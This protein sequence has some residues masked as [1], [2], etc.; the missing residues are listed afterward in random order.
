MNGISDHADM[1]LDALAFFESGD[2]AEQR[3]IVDAAKASGL[4]IGFMSLF[5]SA[6]AGWAD[7]TG[8]SEQALIEQLRADAVRLRD[9]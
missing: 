2:D 8:V 6:L 3:T 1:R 7:A 9:R 4:V 5:G